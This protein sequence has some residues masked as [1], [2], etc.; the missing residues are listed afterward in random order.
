MKLYNFIKN[1]LYKKT[2]YSKKAKPINYM[3]FIGNLSFFR[4]FL[5]IFIVVNY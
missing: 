5:I 3:N 1:R 2:N 4:T